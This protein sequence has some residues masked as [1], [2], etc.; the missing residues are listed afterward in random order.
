[1]SEFERQLKDITAAAFT[2]RG[3]ASSAA[4]SELHPEPA[5]GSVSVHPPK[6]QSTVLVV[7]GFAYDAERDN[8]L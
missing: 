7:G 1:M 5:R 4:S 2:G 8:N 3:A 6:N